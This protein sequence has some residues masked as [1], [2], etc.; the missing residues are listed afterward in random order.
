MAPVGA[1]EHQDCGDESEAARSRRA[2]A[3]QADGSDAPTARG[4]TPPRATSRRNRDQSI[5]PRQTIQPQTTNAAA[6]PDGVTPPAASR[7][8]G[9]REI[10]RGC[11]SVAVMEVDAH[12]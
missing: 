6:V 5:D 9:I 12:K 1:E 4:P 2:E 10:V 8:P 7:P 11:S 3:A